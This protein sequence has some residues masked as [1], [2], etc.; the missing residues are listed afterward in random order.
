MAFNRLPIIA[1][2]ITN[3][4]YSNEFST[5]LTVTEARSLKRKEASNTNT[6]SDTNTNSNSNV[7]N[8]NSDNERLLKHQ[9]IKRDTCE[10][11][12]ALREPSKSHAIHKAECTLCYDNDVSAPLLPETFTF[13]SLNSLSFVV[14][15]MGCLVSNGNNSNPKQV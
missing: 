13:H 8:I 12:E 2:S 14:E 11:V 9:M 3:E 7:I 4:D 6:N 15:L 5:H 10:H 1:A